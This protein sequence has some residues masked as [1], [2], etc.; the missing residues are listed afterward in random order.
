MHLVDVGL[1]SQPTPEWGSLAPPRPPVVHLRGYFLTH[2]L[3][4]LMKCLACLARHQNVARETSL[5]RLPTESQGRQVGC[6]ARAQA[7][8][9]IVP[10]NWRLSQTSQPPEPEVL[11][12]PF[13]QGDTSPIPRACECPRP[14][15]APPLKGQS[16]K[17]VWRAVHQ[18]SEPQCPQA[19]CVFFDTLQPNRRFKR[20]AGRLLLPNQ[21]PPE[22]GPECDWAAGIS[23]MASGLPAFRS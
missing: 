1:N 21:P 5:R 11:T 20:T 4:C 18:D 2:I 12:P 17:R 7:R 16:T 22:K 15:S 6:A 19:G 8:Q 3:N 13:G 23:T 14:H 9:H 10:T